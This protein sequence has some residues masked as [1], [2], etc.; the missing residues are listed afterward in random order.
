M[1]A[2]LES[3]VLDIPYAYEIYVPVKAMPIKMLYSIVT[4]LT[5]IIFLKNTTPKIK[6]AEIKRNAFRNIGGISFMHKSVR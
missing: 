1:N 6:N 4:K 2:A 3:E 5:L